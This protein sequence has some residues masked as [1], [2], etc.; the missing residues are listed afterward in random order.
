MTKFRLIKDELIPTWHRH[1]YEV[2]AETVE[3]AIQKI[4][5]DEVDPYELEFIDDNNGLQALE[6]IDYNDNVLYRE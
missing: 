6:I 5:D 2:E 1:K 4:L 3:E